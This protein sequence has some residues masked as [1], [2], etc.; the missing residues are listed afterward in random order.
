MIIPFYK[1]EYLLSRYVILY[2][3]YLQAPGGARAGW[4]PGPGP[5]GAARR[6]AP[7]GGAARRGDCRL[8]WTTVVYCGQLPFTV[9][10]K[11]GRPVFEFFVRIVKPKSPLNRA[12]IF[13][14]NKHFVC[15]NFWVISGLVIHGKR[16]FSSPN[17]YP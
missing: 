15:T 11:L 4:D 9:D 13:Y 2:V 1:Y 10:R 3:K 6:G 16:Q 8:L 14:E 5:G 17:F 12:H 7:W